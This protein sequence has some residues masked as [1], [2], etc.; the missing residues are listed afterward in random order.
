MSKVNHCIDKHVPVNKPNT[1][2]KKTKWMDQYCVRKVK[3]KYHTWKRFTYIHSYE[4]YEKYCKL[5]NSG[6]KA[7]RFA[8]QRYQRGIVE[9]VKILPKTFLSH[10][11]EETKSKSTIGGIKGTNC[12][13]KTEDTDKT[14]IFNDFLRL[15][16]Q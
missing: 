15:Y 5:R 12:E 3:K 1:K 13:I 14:E 10:V 9:S 2:F 6:S 7:V 8:K 16:L 4:D 11:K